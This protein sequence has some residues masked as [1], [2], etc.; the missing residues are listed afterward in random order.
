[1]A[2][3]RDIEGNRLYHFEL[4]DKNRTVRW[5]LI[6]V[7][8]VVGAI[9]LTF[10]LTK[11]LETPAGWQTVEVSSAKQNCSHEFTFMYDFGAGEMS[12]TQERKALAVLY[13]QLTEN[14][15]QLFY[16]EAGESELNGLWL[17]NQHPNEI[18]RAHV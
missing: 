5:I 11:A 18:G 14:A 8:L 16:N 13:G 6:G 17:L 3:K 2:K 9:A 4:S 12:A 7:L 1:M 10:G 15:W